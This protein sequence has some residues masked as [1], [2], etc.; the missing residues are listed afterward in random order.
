MVAGYSDVLIGLQYGDEGKA[1]VL[2]F[3]LDDYSIV[4]RFN[5]GP[6][7]GHTLEV[8]NIRIS[9][10]QIP[11]GIFHPDMHLYIGSGCVVDPGKAL[12]EMTEIE[13]K[14]LS[15]RER[16][17]ISGYCT[18]IKPNNI[19]EDK[20][21]GGDIGTTQNGVGYAYADQAMRAKGS[22]IANLRLG[23]YL[24]DPE[25]SKENFRQIAMNEYRH[26][27]L[28]YGDEIDIDRLV[29]DFHEEVLKLKPFVSDDPMMLTR[30]VQSGMNVLFE[31][32][33]SVALDVMTGA[34][35]YV[36]SSRTLSAAAYTGGDLSNKH[37]RK[38]IGIAKAIMSRVGNGPFISEFGGFRSESYCG[39]DGGKAHVREKELAAYDPEKMLKSMDMLE[40]GIGLRMIGGEYGATTKRPRRIGM[41]DLVQLRQNCL[42][43][44]VDELYINK[45][46]CLSDFSRTSLP[47]IPL[48][49]GYKL[50][51][52][53]IDYV[54]SAVE[55]ARRAE[56]MITF[57]PKCE[58]DLSKVRR[59]SQLPRQIRD[60]L[61]FIEENV[62]T[63]ICGI[64]VGPERE[65]FIKI[66]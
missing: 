47:G 30:L 25:K 13:S 27:P 54:P 28:H 59:P 36:T 1:R 53:I 42:I 8:G 41:L 61:E 21:F 2:D 49:V 31:G 12:A 20:L 11:S 50:D 17:R 65:Q 10:H 23:D 62:G 44:G 3:L 64:G 38:T 46:D 26:R 16:L 40:I 37:H 33:Q 19:L 18:L 63:P 39:E 7:A 14:G 24:S 15:V 22:V 45:F 32:A 5:G 35:P 48:V 52:K 60:I 43:N 29:D 58:A 9:L 57:F 34:V 4:A 56:P 55:T 51:D 66:R 6:N